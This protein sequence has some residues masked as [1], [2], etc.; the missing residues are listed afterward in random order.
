MGEIDD[1]HA[2]LSANDV[3]QRLK[4][5]DGT[6]NGVVAW[7]KAPEEITSLEQS[8]LAQAPTGN[9]GVRKSS[10]REALSQAITILTSMCK[11]SASSAQ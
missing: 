8:I 4:M 6:F 7:A 9:G 1:N 10:E 2:W 11:T 5:N 3:R